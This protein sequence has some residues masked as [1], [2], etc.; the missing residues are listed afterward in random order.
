MTFKDFIQNIFSIKNVDYRKQI[1]ILG[2]KIKFETTNLILKKLETKLDEHAWRT[3]NKVDEVKSVVLASKL[4]GYLEKYRGIYQGKDVV[5]I[6]CDPTL[7]YFEPIKDAI[8]MGVNKAYKYEKI[9]F[10]YIYTT[11]NEAGMDELINYKPDTC[12]KFFSYPTHDWKHR[13]HLNNFVKSNPKIAV[14]NPNLESRMPIDLANESFGSY[15]FSSTVLFALQFALYTLP[16][17]IFIVGCDCSQGNICRKKPT[18]VNPSDNYEY[19]L[20][21]WKLMKEDIQNLFPEIEIIS[22]NPV[23]LKGYFKDVY[24]KSYVDKHPELQ[25]ENVEIM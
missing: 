8:Y 1:T 6:G 4:H 9:N 11:D 25:K 15:W 13:H 17:R 14:L 20:Y 10:D 16:K 12:T 21:G 23:N 19:Q 2:I 5:I 22:I 18:K 3:Q 7:E 24:T